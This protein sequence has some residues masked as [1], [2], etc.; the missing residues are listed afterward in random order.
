MASLTIQV[1]GAF[2][3]T[4]SAALTLELPRHLLS[5]IGFVGAGGYLAY[6][7]VLDYNPVLAAFVAAFIITIISQIFAR[8]FKAPVTM[9]YIP[10]FFPIVPGIAIYR[11]VLY[12]IQGDLAQANYYLVQTMMVAGAIAIAIFLIDSYIEMQN[13]VLHQRRL[14][15]RKNQ[16]L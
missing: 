13:F 7:L 10:G 4:V 11:T 6:L 8:V 5:N 14:R 9:F 3:A 12:F 15:L 1:I 16:E 2:I